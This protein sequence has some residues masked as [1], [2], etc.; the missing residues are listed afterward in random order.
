MTKVG[1]DGDQARQSIRKQLLMV[2]FLPIL[3]AIVHLGFAYQ[4]VIRHP[5]SKLVWR[6][7]EI[8]VTCNNRNSLVYF[9][10]YLMVFVVNKHGLINGL[11]LKAWGFPQVF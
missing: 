4:D 11:L 7:Y 5:L 8:N 9:L 6:K 2:F 10:L 3:L 1:L